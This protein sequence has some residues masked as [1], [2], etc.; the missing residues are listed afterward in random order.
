[1]VDLSR[2]RKNRSSPLDAWFQLG[3]DEEAVWT[4]LL[5]GPSLDELGS[6]L[7]SIPRD[8]LDP[9]ASLRAIAGDLYGGAPRHEVTEVLEQAQPIDAS[10][11]AAAIALWLWASEELVG[12]LEPGIATGWTPVA[13][14]A[15]AFRLAPVVDPAEWLTDA[16][17]REE[18]AR[19]F[20]LWC[21][22]L[23]AGES[24]TVAKSLWER[25]DSLRRNA[26]MQAMLADHQHRVEVTAELRKKA[27]MEAAARY[28]HE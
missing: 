6:R 15:L 3:Q 21:G 24:A 13:I 9:R 23:P 16:A 10:R 26:A 22:Y 2:F 19:L 17:R 25:H 12:P 27:A 8:F 7:S 14:A 18:A 1:M 5:P 20:L 28:T 4:R 11:R